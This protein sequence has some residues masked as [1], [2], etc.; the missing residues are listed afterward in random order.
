MIPGKRLR[1]A[2][3]LIYLIWD[4]RRDRDSVEQTTS[5]KQILPQTYVCVG[6]QLNSDE[7]LRILCLKG[8]VKVRDL[9]RWRYRWQEASK[10]FCIKT[11]LEESWA[12]KKIAQKSRKYS[13]LLISRFQNFA[14][15]AAENKTALRTVLINELIRINSGPKIL[16]SYFLHYVCIAHVGCIWI[17]FVLSFLQIVWYTCLEN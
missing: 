1:K 3:L 7:A 5:I 2:L 4:I 13:L 14:A 15:Y 11:P 12:T 16:G 6:C 8:H 10:Y 17:A 9:T